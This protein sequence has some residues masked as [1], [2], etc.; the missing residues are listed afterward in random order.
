VG[1]SAGTVVVGAPYKA[2]MA[3]VGTSSAA[4]NPASLRLLSEGGAGFVYDGSIV[5]VRF[6]QAVY[7]VNENHPTVF[8][9]PNSVRIQ[10]QRRGD[11]SQALSVGY[12]TSD[13][14]ANGISEAMLAFCTGV[15]Y[16]ERG[17]H[18]CGDYVQQSGI[19]TF[20]PH[21]SEVEFTLR[22]VN[23]NCNENRP[24]FVKLQLSLP[25]GPPLLGAPYVAL[26]RIDDD[27][28]AVPYNRLFCPQ[29][30]ALVSPNHP[31]YSLLDDRSTHGTPARA[32]HVPRT[33]LM[34]WILEEE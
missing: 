17:Q 27:D 8:S 26:L 24:E 33:E 11:L 28:G 2:A 1:L 32:E 4:F 22:T 29:Q 16:K 31:L 23:D 30:S 20:F 15:F 19:I 9:Y 3:P 10:V 21:D 14:T 12:S 7:V 18:F 6:K 25:G 5:N 13:L 34:D